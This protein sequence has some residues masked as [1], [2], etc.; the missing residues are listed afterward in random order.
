MRLNTGNPDSLI[1]RRRIT[2]VVGGLLLW[3]ATTSLHA[4]TNFAINWYSID[5]G[6]G[7]STGATYTVTGTIGQPDA[8]TMS[9]GGFALAGGFWGII[10]T[11]PTPGAPTLQIARSITNSVIV[12]WPSP[13][14]GWRLQQNTNVNTTNWTDVA[15]TPG[16]D[17]TTKSKTVSPPLGNRFYRLITP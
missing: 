10:S 13:S 15:Q 5:G 9:G 2:M 17:G 6:G 7:S 14:T 11:V 3:L 1:S 8:G 4:Q 12:S 16:D